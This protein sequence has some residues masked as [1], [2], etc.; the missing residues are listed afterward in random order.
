MPTPNLESNSFISCEKSFISSAVQ[1]YIQSINTA[2]VNMVLAE[3]QDTHC[4]MI[5]HMFLLP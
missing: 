4:F 3:E 1:D 5:V 2:I